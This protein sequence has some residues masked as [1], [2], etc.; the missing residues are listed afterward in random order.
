M[1]NIFEENDNY[2][3][4]LNSF[5]TAGSIMKESIKFLSTK[6]LISQEVFSSEIPEGFS[7]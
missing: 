4:V 2:N 6:N 3:F 1:Q 5:L 7:T